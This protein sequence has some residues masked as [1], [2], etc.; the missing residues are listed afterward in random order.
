MAK[1]ERLTGEELDEWETILEDLIEICDD[2]EQRAADECN[3]KQVFVNEDKAKA[4]EMRK[5]AMETMGE[6]RSRTG[7]GSKEE[8]RRSA[9][10]AFQ[11]L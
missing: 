11:W 1:A 10:Q 7:E 9:N 3:E 4:M 2:V 5:R 6:T 8:K